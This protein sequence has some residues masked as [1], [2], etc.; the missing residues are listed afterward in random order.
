M[1][2]NI[3]IKRLFN[4]SCI[5]LIVTAMTFAIRTD[6]IGTLGVQFNL[7]NTQMGIVGGT[8]FW[9]F[10]LAMIFG[11]FLVDI[12]GMRLLVYLAF[13]THL[14]GIILT[15]FSGGFWSLFISTLL[16]GIG[17]GMVEAACN[18]L[19]ATIYPEGRTKMLN[20]FHVWFPGG[21]VIGGMVA[22][23]FGKIDLG[24]EAQMASMLLP[25]LIYGIMFLGIKF[26]KTERAS[27]GTSYSDMVKS[28][29]NPLFIVMVLCMLLTAST[30]LGTEQ[31]IKELLGSVK[32]GETEV[33]A[34]V[35]LIF[36]SGIMVL[37]RMFAG[38]VIH[39]LAPEGMLL[40]SAI[41]ALVGLHWISEASGGT[42]FLAATVFAI[43]ICYFW[44]TMIGFVSEY[45]P[46][47]G[48]LGLSLMGGAGMLSVALI[49]PIMGTDFDQHTLEFL[50]DGTTIEDLK[51]MREIAN[52]IKDSAEAKILGQA[53]LEAGKAT[54]KDVSLLPLVLIGAFTGIFF[55]MRNRK[56]KTIASE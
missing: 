40:F 44:P 24:W 50:S 9:G 13:F 39:K 25:L 45:L 31:W 14:A 38:P 52:K 47:T 11:G 5:A 56:Q 53:Q 6:V 17:N 49:L 21:I 18:P 10:T 34:I 28:I 42:L 8:A 27:S 12:V 19:I 7:D 4:A 3:Q 26:P 36:I 30:E 33:S 22:Y 23:S 2:E 16:V 41:F 20:R 1:S 48:A 29:F 37:G 43:G 54:I 51:G 46:N 32:I 15:I 55:F 35:I